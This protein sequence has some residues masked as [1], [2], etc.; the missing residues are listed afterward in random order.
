MLRRALPGD[1]SARV[2]ASRLKEL[3]ALG[4]VHRKDQQTLP[5]NVEYSLTQAGKALDVVLMKSEERAAE[6]F[7]FA[8]LKSRSGSRSS[9]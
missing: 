8:K 9:G 1:V 2:L 7:Q 4:L 6:L 5:L 3:V